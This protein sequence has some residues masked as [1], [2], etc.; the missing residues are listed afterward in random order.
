LEKDRSS[1]ANS[2]I[3]DEKHNIRTNAK[4]RAH[5]KRPA[6]DQTSVKQAALEGSHM[7]QVALVNRNTLP[8][9]GSCSDRAP[10]LF[11]VGF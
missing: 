6:T 2:G 4:L 7:S 9:A 3:L 10:P 1:S 5:A 11:G 8:C